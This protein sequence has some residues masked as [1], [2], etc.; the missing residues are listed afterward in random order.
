[1]RFILTLLFALFCA[2]HPAAASRASRVL[3]RHRRRRPRSDRTRPDG[4]RGSWNPPDQPGLGRRRVRAGRPA[5]LEPLRHPD[6][7][8]RAP[9]HPRAADGV[10]LAALGG[11]AGFLSAL[12]EALGDYS[13]FVR[14]AA[15]RYGSN[16]S[17]WSEHPDIPRLPVRRLAAL[18]RA[19]PAGL[20][21]AQAERQS[22]VALLRVFSRAIR[23]R[24]SRLRT[25]C[26]PGSFRA[27]PATATSSASRSSDT[28]RPSTGRRTPRSCSTASTSIHTPPLRT[29]SWPT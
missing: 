14:P 2:P 26:S 27:R 1:M 17:F 8:R 21:A 7:R 3:R 5:R 19:E 15:A 24:R 29:A 11:G 20:L 18:E 6:R 22:Y 9:G 10:Q 28:S 13:R 16:G 4:H 25:S 23:Q 12:A